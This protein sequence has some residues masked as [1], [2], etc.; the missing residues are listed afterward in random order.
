MHKE[1]GMR[2]YV[3]SK[4]ENH[5]AVSELAALLRAAG[6]E[7]TYDWTTHG[8]VKET[9]EAT[10]REVGHRELRGVLDADVLLM[11]TPQGRGSH[12]ELGI[13]LAAGKRVYIHHEDGRYFRCDDETSPF[14]W[15]DDVV[16]FAGTLEELARQAIRD[17]MP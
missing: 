14:Y 15:N 12:V 7:Q 16:R 8:S 11:L 3:A 1:R 6:W 13:A 10:L 2:F 4:L 17:C 5:E 9:D